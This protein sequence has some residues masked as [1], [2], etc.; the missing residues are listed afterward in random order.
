MDIARIF[1]ERDAARYRELVGQGAEWPGE[2]KADNIELMTY[3]V[4]AQTNAKRLAYWLSDVEVPAQEYYCV[5][6]QM[7]RHARGPIV[8]RNYPYDPP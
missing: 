5:S 2:W 3:L 4:V 1:C 8:L 7:P 6:N